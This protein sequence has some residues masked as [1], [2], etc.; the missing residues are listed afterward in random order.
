MQY[1]FSLPVNFVFMH[2][3]HI[4]LDGKAKNVDPDQA[5]PSKG[6]CLHEMSK[7]IY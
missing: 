6:D 5:A 1:I 3:F 2:L 7:P 4:I